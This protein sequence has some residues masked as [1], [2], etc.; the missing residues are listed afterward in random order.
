MKRIA[1]CC[2]MN[3]NRSMEVHRLLLENNIKCK[4]F[5]TQSVV[6]LPSPDA[7]KANTYKYDNT[8]ADI[9]KDLE[10][11]HDVWY[12]QT[13]LID[14]VDKN[15]KTKE[16]PENIFQ[17]AESMNKNLIE[18]FDLIV[19]CDKRCYNALIEYAEYE[20]EERKKI[21]KIVSRDS[22]C[23]VVNFHIKDSIADAQSAANSVVDFVKRIF[24]RTEA[25]ISY[26]NAVKRVI[27]DFSQE[28]N[29]DMLFKVL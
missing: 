3:Q 28:M 5:G 12:E 14:M 22:H 10:S 8:F 21:K 19:S 6:R 24:R 2:A 20:E 29:E 27:T 13:G 7:L 15:I 25:G 4:S 16:K 1:I 26:D 17:Y 9:K 18:L 23:W 11:K